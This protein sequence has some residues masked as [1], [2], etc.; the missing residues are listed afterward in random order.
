MPHRRLSKQSS[1]FKYRLAQEVINLRNKRKE[2]LLAFRRDELQRKA[3]QMDGKRRFQADHAPVLKA[4]RTAEKS[5]ACR[6]SNPNILVM[7]PAQDWKA[8]NTPCPLN[9][10]R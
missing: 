8:K 4:C 6:K 9:R 10:A 7:Q 2:C 5:W 1:T 3:C